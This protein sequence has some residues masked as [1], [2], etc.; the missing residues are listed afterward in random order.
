MS[1]DTTI[2][3]TRDYSTKRLARELGISRA[4]LLETLRNNEVPLDW[5]AGTS[6]WRIRHRADADRAIHHYQLE[7]E[8]DAA[9]ADESAAGT[10]RIARRARIRAAYMALEAATDEV[11]LA[12][13]AERDA[14]AA[15]QS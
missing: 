14:A 3:T 1:T 13:R 15:E 12:Q 9:E 5:H 11:E 4:E 7:R 8:D 2:R 10:A 6:T